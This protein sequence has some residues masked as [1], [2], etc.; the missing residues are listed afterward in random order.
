MRFMACF[1]AQSIDNAAIGDCDQ[2]R[3]ERPFRV[4][5]VADHVN[6]QQNVLHGVFYVAWLLKAS[7]CQ[8]T[9]IRGHV[10]Q[11]SPIGLTITVLRARHEL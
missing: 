9:K 10:L 3:A 11:E 5:G 4:V 7:R 8:R 2:P 6:G 1:A